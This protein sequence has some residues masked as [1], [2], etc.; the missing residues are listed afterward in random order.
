MSLDDQAVKDAIAIKKEV[1]S[2][3]IRGHMM[4]G[5]IYI[6]GAKPGDTLEVRVLDIKSRLPYGI[7]SGGPGRGGI[8]DQV[9][10]PYSKFIPLDLKRNVAKFSDKIEIPLKQFQGVM[11]VAPTPEK[12]KLP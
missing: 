11:A 7:N 12:G 9:P 8:P 3:G 5:P 2:S 4:T 6:E 10:R 1:K